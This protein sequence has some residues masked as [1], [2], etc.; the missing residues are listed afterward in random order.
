VLSAPPDRAI[1]DAIPVRFRDRRL[2]GY[3]ADTDS[4]RLA[5]SAAERVVGGA[6]RNLVLIGEPGV[7]KTHLAAAIAAGIAERDWLDYA[8][9]CDSAAADDRH[10]AVPD[11][12][13]WLNV[14]DAIVQMRLEFETPAYDRS[15]T[16][17]LL[18]GREYRGLVVL[19]DLGRERV[20]DWTGE[21]I[22]ALVNARYEAMLPTIV[23]SN[24]TPKELGEGPYWPAL[25]RL[26]EDGE[27]IEV[28]G[29]DRRLQ[30]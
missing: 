22:Y 24:L 3:V 14:A 16:N 18:G 17:A 10:P 2:S 4:Q 19:D 12:P 13:H 20:S 7:G 6:I 25:S 11:L 9:A 27:L 21:V 30:R 23:T 15:A 1:L 5:V 28:K 26:A 29:P 8:A